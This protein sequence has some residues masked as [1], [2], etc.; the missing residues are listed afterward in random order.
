M[1]QLSFRHASTTATAATRPKIDCTEFPERRESSG[2]RARRS[3][4]SLTIWQSVL[5]VTPPSVCLSDRHRE[6]KLTP[7][8]LAQRFADS[9]LRLRAFHGKQKKSRAD[10][11]NNGEKTTDVKF[12]WVASFI[13]GCKSRSSASGDREGNG[14]SLRSAAMRKIRLISASWKLKGRSD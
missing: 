6:A 2:A 4:N 14:D 5:R 8:K 12:L 11:W 7:R 13:Q 9:E 1:Q 10:T 3:L